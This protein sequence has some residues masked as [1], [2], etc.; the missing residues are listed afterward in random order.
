[1][2]TNPKPIQ[3]TENKGRWKD[4]R[5]ETRGGRETSRE[6]GHERRAERVRVPMFWVF[7]FQTSAKLQITI[8]LHY[9][10]K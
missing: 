3:H 9:K 6:K 8:T 4:K 1:M 7:G 5:T 2:V 10:L